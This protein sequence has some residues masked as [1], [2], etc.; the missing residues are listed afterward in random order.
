M[1]HKHRN[2][3]NHYHTTVR[4]LD[5]LIRFVSLLRKETGYSAEKAVIALK[6]IDRFAPVSYGGGIIRYRNV[7][8]K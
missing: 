5:S 4:S 6:L 3:S 1:Q 2:W 8:F 7:G